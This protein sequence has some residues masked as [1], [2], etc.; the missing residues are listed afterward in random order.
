MAQ[1]G[2]AKKNKASRRT[3]TNRAAR[4]GKVSKLAAARST[5]PAGEARPSKT[6]TS[7]AT[8]KKVTGVNGKAR[9]ARTAKSKPPAGKASK[10]K[11]AEPKAGSKKPPRGAR[12]HAAP[13]D[14]DA[15]SAVVCKVLSTIDY[16]KIC[17]DH[18]NPT[19]DSVPVDIVIMPDFVVDVDGAA[20]TKLNT[21]AGTPDGRAAAAQIGSRAGR[22]LSI[23]AHLRDRDDEGFRLHYIAKTG[24][25]GRE[26]LRER[27]QRDFKNRLEPVRFP[28]LVPTEHTRFTALGRKK[29]TDSDAERHIVEPTEHSMLKTSELKRHFYNPLQVIRSANA[30]YFATDSQRQFDELIDTVVVAKDVAQPDAAAP[31]DDS[32]ATNGA[33]R[34]VFVDLAAIKYDTDGKQAT[35]VPSFTRLNRT[36]TELKGNDSLAQ[37]TCVVVIIDEP[38]SPAKRTSLKR[39]FTKLGLRD[40]QDLLVAYHRVDGERRVRW[41]QGAPAQLLDLDLTLP[42]AREAFV[43]GMVL[44][45]AVASA[46]TAIP[47]QDRL[48][49]ELGQKPDWTK[50]L[51]PDPYTNDARTSHWEEKQG[52]TRTFKNTVTHTTFEET[53]LYSAP[54]IEA[55]L[56]H[57]TTHWPID[58]TIKFAAALHE[59]WNTPP[60]ADPPGCHRLVQLSC[61]ADK[62]LFA[63]TP[64]AKWYASVILNAAKCATEPDA[65]ATQKLVGYLWD[66]V[67][68]H[69]AVTRPTSWPGPSATQALKPASFKAIQGLGA[70]RALRLLAPEKGSGLKRLDRNAAYLTDLDG[71]LLRSSGLRSLCVKNALLAMLITP[72]EADKLKTGFP[73][74]PQRDIIHQSGESQPQTLLQML[75]TCSRLYHVLV[76]KQAKN[77]EAILEAYPYDSSG[78]PPKDFRQVWNHPLSYP[79]FLWIVRHLS[80]E[81]NRITK[82]LPPLPSEILVDDLESQAITSLRPMLDG[83][84]LQCESKLKEFF[85]IDET[86]VHGRTKLVAN[87]EPRLQA[88]WIDIANIE[89]KYKPHFDDALARYWDVHFEPFRHTKECL[90]TLRDVY[91]AKLYVAT[92][93]HHETQLRKLDVLGLRDFFSNMTVLSTEAAASTHEDLRYIRDAI[94]NRDTRIRALESVSKLPGLQDSKGAIQKD[95][96]TAKTD[97][98]HLALYEEQWRNFEDKT[99]GNIYPLIVASVMIAPETPFVGLTD[100]RHVV[101]TLQELQKRRKTT[102]AKAIAPTHFAMVGDREK[103]DIR[104]IIQSCQQHVTAVRLLTLD[105]QYED[106]C[107]QDSGAEAHYVAWTPVQALL[108]LAQPEA[109]KESLDFSTVPAIINGRLANLDGTINAAWLN[110]LL[111]ESKLKNAALKKSLTLIQFLVLRGTI[112]ASD[113]RDEGFVLAVKGALERNRARAEKDEEKGKTREETYR[114][115]LTLA[116]N[117][118]F[119]TSFMP[120]DRQLVMAEVIRDAISAEYQ[121]A[122]TDRENENLCS[123][124]RSVAESV[125]R[126][127]AGPPAQCAPPRDDEQGDEQNRIIAAELDMNVQQQLGELFQE[128]RDAWEQRCKSQ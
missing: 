84:I 106:V 5:A 72:T 101:T 66:K 118:A 78:R 31:Q 36:I 37:R 9:Q 88:F 62:P 55:E 90:R 29:H 60:S 6:A 64:P 28:Y 10:H 97:E 98:R 50:G 76:Y 42:D 48:R 117:I 67:A 104:P 51:F 100:L 12:V 34:T 93:G 80:N 102:I 105:H 44:H 107:W 1:A 87:N 69:G 35:G 91:G 95:W 17:A 89:V 21:S 46:W 25:I 94:R 11:S 92:E 41:S 7:K 123:T 26:V 58:D 49:H 2:N 127:L 73:V 59:L 4:S 56:K 77:W 115:M 63:N 13:L 45:R 3:A 33:L 116:R 30:L 79:V 125:F 16:L 18:Y 70:L 43:A 85:G 27:L 52:V 86:K 124:F 113:I 40:N 108:C 15:R 109:W 126:Q 53:K 57:L 82:A 112:R 83:G 68:H 47:R 120:E 103:K 99:V 20:I 23:L 119:E 75:E 110:A 96:K 81:G 122:F 24:R 32:G 19:G 114:F 38:K 22:V 14:S 39:H 128:W 8:R 65:H 111:W 74:L 121:N 54:D 61:R 71:T